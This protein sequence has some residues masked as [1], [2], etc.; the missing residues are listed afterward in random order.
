M[1]QNLNNNSNFKTRAISFVKENRIKF[2]FFFITILLFFATFFIFIEHQ[3]QKNILLAEKYIKAG[4]L[5]NNGEVDE[6]QK[7]YKNI[8]QNNNKFYSL[9]TLNTLIEKNLIKD[10]KK[11]LNYFSELEK[12][13]FSSE[14]MD[15]IYFKKALY[16]IKIGDEKSGKNILKNLIDKDSNLKIT[17]KEIIN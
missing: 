16:L 1:E 2:S 6:A 5:L 3:K 10:E 7:H 17:A 11:I 8:L 4:I 12:K 9:L 14:L 13:N 15:L